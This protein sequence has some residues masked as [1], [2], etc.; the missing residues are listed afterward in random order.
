M[1]EN[2]TAQQGAGKNKK[3]IL[4]AAACT[5]GAILLIYLALCVYVGATRTVLP[6]VGVDELDLG[7]LTQE[8]ASHA[9][10]QWAAQRY[11]GVTYTL[12]CGGSSA[13][14]SGKHVMVDD[15]VIARNAYMVGRGEPFLKRGAVILAHIFGGRTSIPA[16]PGLD[17]E[18][19]RAF[20]LAMEQLGR[21]E[22]T[23]LIETVWSVENYVLV[24]TRGVTGRTVEEEQARAELALSMTQPG[25]QTVEV[26]V[27]NVLP[28]PVDF[29]QIHAQLYAEAKDSFVDEEKYEAM[30]HVVGIDFD[31]ELAAREFESLAEGETMTVELTV[32]MPELTQEKLHRMLFRD[33]LGECTTSISGTE[34]R[35]NNV[36]VAAKAIDGVV[37]MPGEVFSYNDTLGP[38]TTAQGYRPAPAYIGGKT[39][40]DIGGGICQDSSTLYLATLRANLEIVE[41]V[42]HMYAVGYVPDGLDATVAY[43][44]IDFR[45]RNDTQY[46][47]CID[48]RV[49][50][51][52]I[53]VKILGTKEQA[54][55]VKMV[56][57]TLSTTPYQVIYKPDHTVP[58]G[59]TV[60]DT[61][62]YTGRKVQAYRCV[63]DA[64]GALVSKTL[65][66]TN[67]YRHRDKVILYN[68]ADAAGLGLVDKEG[69]VHSTVLPVV[70]EP[71][72]EPEVPEPV[73]P[74]PEPAPEP[75]PE[76]TPE[77][78]QGQE[79]AGPEPGTESEQEQTPRPLPGQDPEEVQPENSEGET[80]A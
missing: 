14:L 37:L 33:V 36:I 57:Q 51:R 76:P 46:P 21:A 42:N 69:N 58:V 31:A 4:L 61:T 28:Q 59:K 18:G 38:R 43:N 23:P 39:V 52:K 29:K 35:L 62:A 68:P 55:T 3:R 11:D 19:V 56:T 44:A 32:T 27:I 63:Y 54:F 71:T 70:P 8:Q 78:E 74:A 12:R 66:S 79:T 75:E 6:G 5:A 34:N 22:N 48:A 65:E 80:A 30:P 10:Q 26:S 2:L 50:G 16:R 9:V 7:G 15:A 67:N 20:E 41:R 25:D 64:N 13:Q 53:T 47:I 60:V 77:P 17:S 72:P 73:T 45:F 40:D 1:E 24:V 49:N